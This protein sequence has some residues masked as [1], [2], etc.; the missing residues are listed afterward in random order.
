MRLCRC[1][2]VG[3]VNP[4]GLDLYLSLREHSVGSSLAGGRSPFFFFFFCTIFSCSWVQRSS[5]T[6]VIGISYI[7]RKF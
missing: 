4:A 6:F 7:E 1:V 5:K 2:V 3:L